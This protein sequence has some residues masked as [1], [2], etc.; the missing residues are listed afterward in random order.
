MITYIQIGPICLL[1]NGVGGH[2]R[3]EQVL[4]IVE[5]DLDREDHV[6]ALFLGSD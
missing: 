4:R 6:H 2:A 1:E 3:L 5:A